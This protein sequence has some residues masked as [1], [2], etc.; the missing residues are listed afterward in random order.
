MR[1]FSD[2]L[3]LKA[4]LISP[5]LFFLEAYPLHINPS[6]PSPA[7]PFLDRDQTKHRVPL[8]VSAWTFLL[9]LLINYLPEVWLGIP[10][11][12]TTQC[13]VLIFCFTLLSHCPPFH[14]KSI[15]SLEMSLRGLGLI[16][17]GVSWIMYGTVSEFIYILTFIDINHSPSLNIIK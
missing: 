11:R 12:N 15:S 1:S 7:F 13:C 10:C 16:R 9:L 4:F 2:I 17:F 5:G 14:A 3:D 6:R 8:E